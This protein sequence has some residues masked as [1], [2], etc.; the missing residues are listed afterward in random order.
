M[1]SRDFLGV[2]EHAI[3]LVGLGEHLRSEGG[4]DELSGLGEGVDH[5]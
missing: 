3:E 5:S 4:G 1:D 2:K